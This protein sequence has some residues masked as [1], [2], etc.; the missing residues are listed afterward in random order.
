MLPYVFLWHVEKTENVDMKYLSILLSYFLSF[1]KDCEIKLFVK[2]LQI[3]TPFKNTRNMTKPTLKENC[4]HPRV[5]ELVYPLM[6]IHE[7]RFFYYYY[8]ISLF[9]RIAEFWG[10]NVLLMLYWYSATSWHIFVRK[11]RREL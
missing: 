9:Y 10:I 8:A 7:W 4:S 6:L 2:D 3:Q 1:W 5:K 11:M